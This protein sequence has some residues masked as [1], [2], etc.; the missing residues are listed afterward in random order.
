MNHKVPIVEL[1]NPKN[2][3]VAHPGKTREGG[4]FPYD[5]LL[6]TGSPTEEI[7]QKTRGS[8]Q[9]NIFVNAR[10]GKN[11]KK[12]PLKAKP[13]LD[14]RNIS[15]NQKRPSPQV[16][17]ESGDDQKA[18]VK[19]GSRAS[20]PVK[21]LFEADRGTPADE[22]KLV[23]RSKTSDQTKNTGKRGM[24]EMDTVPANPLMKPDAN[25]LINPG[26][27]NSKEN[28]QAQLKTRIARSANVKVGIEPDRRISD[29]LKAGLNDA[30]Q[31]SGIDRSENIVTTKPAPMKN[32]TQNTTPPD[33]R[34]GSQ[35][36]R[37][38]GHNMTQPASEGQKI[39]NAQAIPIKDRAPASAN[40]HPVG[41]KSTT[42][43]EPSKINA[44]KNSAAEQPTMKMTKRSQGNLEKSTVRSNSRDSQQI[45]RESKTVIGQI[46]SKS[47][48]MPISTPE[49]KDT[50]A[51][52]TH[53]KPSR[54]EKVEVVQSV[55]P[56]QKAG[57]QTAPDTISP[58][59]PVVEAS[60]VQKTNGSEESKPI[61]SKSNPVSEKSIENHSSDRV[62]KSSES[63]AQQAS[64]V[65]HIQN[66]V[67]HAVDRRVITSGSVPVAREA[68][69]QD[70]EIVQ[71]QEVAPDSEKIIKQSSAAMIMGEAD[72]PKSAKSR[73][74]SQTTKRGVSRKTNISPTEHLR[75]RQIKKIYGT[76]AVHE[77]VVDPLSDNSTDILKQQLHERINVL[78][79]AQE[80]ITNSPEQQSDQNFNRDVSMKANPGL[81]VSPGTET[82]GFYSRTNAA[83]FTRSFASE[84]V[85]KIR[86]I[87]D[88]KLTGNGGL[89]TS[90][91]VDGGQMGQ[92][93][94]EFQ[95]ESSKEQV[96]IFVDSENSRID[97][98]RLMPQI[99]DNL[100]QRGF[101]FAGLDV[102]VRSD[103]K[104]SD[105]ANNAE[106]DSSHSDKQEVT[107][108]EKGM[109]DESK[110]V[111]NRNYGYNTMEVLA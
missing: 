38:P 25:V 34:E 62:S 69:N 47:K 52:R 63:K 15:Q 10:F 48:Q 91:V 93:D 95:Q 59:R 105:S 58:T 72:K 22:T 55:E 26:K 102:E 12:I 1:K 97:L 101:S 110:S 37:N 64:K 77:K 99:E 18:E 28:L 23:A 33:L 5:D 13:I 108:S 71:K 43:Q 50:P 66:T 73:K 46:N 107:S 100:Q 24:Q 79:K 36:N 56:L 109:S 98:M 14:T 57:K 31:R 81:N 84:M 17:A 82:S 35:Q 2:E 90:F 30:K 68:I 104:E 21:T 76:Q 86:A 32:E 6:K 111:T 39:A 70:L 75:T 41:E 16:K 94:I 106:K 49:P 7:I 8:N 44:G 65:N 83:L 51:D 96:T 11:G 45:V 80:S 85:E 78:K 67:S 29:K 88:S 103:Q 89:K 42:V 4:E 19:P 9:A 87:T 53:N 27:E 74:Q 54:P 40:S 20:E 3:A 60:S 61:K 92:L